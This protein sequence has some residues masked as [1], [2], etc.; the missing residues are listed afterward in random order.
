MIA[1]IV[2]AAGG[3]RRYGRANKLLQP[4][5][6]RPLLAWSLD[7][8]AAMSPRRIIVVTGDDRVRIARAVRRWGTPAATI[9][10]APDWRCGLGAS[11][12]RGIA[13]LRPVE[14]AALIFLGDM[15]AADAGVARRMLRALAPG[16]MVVRP[17][18][19]GQ[20]GHPVLVRAAFARSAAIDGDRGLAPAIRELPAA[21]RARV[22]GTRGSI[23]DIDRPADLRRHKHLRRDRKSS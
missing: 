19:R 10:H 12:T 14:R 13:A 11:L 22:V 18:W 21:A 20:A 16:R 23:I 5:G 6:G 15:P 3:S 8:A 2:L 17:F 4:L 9:V 7:A 1:A